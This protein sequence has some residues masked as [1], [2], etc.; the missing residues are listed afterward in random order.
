MEQLIAYLNAERGRRKALA[1]S[2]GIWPS[3]ISMWERVPSERVLEIERLTGI[4]RHALRPDI[5]G[6]APSE[7]AQ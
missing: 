1:Q 3:N 5:Y 2:L 6:P 7:A 4:S